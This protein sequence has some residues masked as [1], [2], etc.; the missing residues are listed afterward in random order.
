MFA[1]AVIPFPFAYK[2]EMFFFSSWNLF[3]FVSALPAL[4]TGFWLITLPETPKFLAENGRRD[5]LLKV[6]TRMFT[7]NTGKTAEQFKV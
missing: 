7:E 4:L 2:T 5:E 6:L 3:V 1:W